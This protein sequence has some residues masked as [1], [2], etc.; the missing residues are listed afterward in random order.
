MLNEK[1]WVIF[2]VITFLGINISAQE[3]GFTFKPFFGNGGGG[4]DLF[5][6]KT[7]SIYLEIGYLQHFLNNEIIG[8]VSISI[9][10]R[11]YL[12]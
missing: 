2:L 12:K 8:G 3:S 7:C 6:H 10:T 11:G 9:G 5:Y 1:K 4:I